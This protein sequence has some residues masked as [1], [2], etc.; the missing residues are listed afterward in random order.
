MEE[1]ECGVSNDGGLSGE[2]KKEGKQGW[3][4][5]FLS[6]LWINDESCV[7]V[8]ASPELVQGTVPLFQEN[9]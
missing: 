1:E 8:G 2:R 5:V 4:R 7:N 9:K 6:A 3:R